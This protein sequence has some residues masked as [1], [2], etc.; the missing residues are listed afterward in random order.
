MTTVFGKVYDSLDYTK[1]SEPKLRLARPGLKEKKNSTRK[2]GKEQKNR[3]KKIRGT[4][5]A[6][7][8]A[9]KKLAGEWTTER[10][11]ILQQIY[12]W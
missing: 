8:G 7:I 5:K 10:V 11:K 2:Q 6:S 3:M 1:K 9:G 12:L 4:A